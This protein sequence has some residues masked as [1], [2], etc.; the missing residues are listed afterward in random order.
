MPVFL[1]MAVALMTVMVM[2]VVVPA[3][4]LE[5]FFTAMTKTTDQFSQSLGVQFFTGFQVFEHKFSHS[6][7]SLL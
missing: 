5:L 4:M 6:C 1:P 7:F 2:M 3:V